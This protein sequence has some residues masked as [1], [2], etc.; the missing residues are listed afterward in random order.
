MKLY[1]IQHAEAMD[2]EADA[3]RRLTAAGI[4]DIE[5]IGQFLERLACNVPLVIHSSR[6]RARETAERVARHIGPEA[7]IEEAPALGP[8]DSAAPWNERLRG[9]DHDVAL[10]G[11]M[12]FLSRLGS[13]LLTGTEDDAMIAFEKSAVACLVCDEVRCWR[14]AWMVPPEL[15]AR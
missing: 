3:D 5:L 1:L 7:K 14:L 10:I 11:H 4:R 8:R 12:P 9:Y 6:T 13:L 2:A 15:V